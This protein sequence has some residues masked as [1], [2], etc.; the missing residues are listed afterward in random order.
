METGRYYQRRGGE[1]V[2]QRLRLVFRQ[3]EQDALF[4]CSARHRSAR[5]AGDVEAGT[6]RALRLAACGECIE[7]AFEP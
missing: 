5:P 4:E 6:L 1:Q 7:D 3:L 2:P